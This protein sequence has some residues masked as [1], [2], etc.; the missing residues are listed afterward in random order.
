LFGALSGAVPD[1]VTAD[2]AGGSTL[3]TIAGYQDGKAFV[4]CETFMGTWGATSAHDGQQ[5]V[6]HMGAN[7]CNVS[8]EAIENDYPIRINEY[9]MLPDTGGAGQFRGG[10]SLVREYEILSDEAVLNV[11]SDKRRFPPHGLFG[12]HDGAPSWNYLNPGRSDRILPVLM[13]EVEKLRNGDVFRHEM[14]GGG[15]FGDPLKREPRYVLRDVREEKVSIAHALQDYGV[16]IVGHGEEQ[17]VDEAATHR[18]RSE[19]RAQALAV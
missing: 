10:L 4:F 18:S 1:R 2:T 13:T 15:G 12:G 5:G 8:V 11:R 17:R 3:P 14:A 16:V 6:P 7:Q 9:G 19:L